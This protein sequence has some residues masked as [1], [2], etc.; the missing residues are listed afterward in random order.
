MNPEEKQKL[1][2]YLGEIL[3]V[4]DEGRDEA[5][6][7]P[8]WL[9]LLN[10]LPTILVEWLPFSV[11]LPLTPIFLKYIEANQPARLL[12]LFSEDG[13]VLI[14]SVVLCGEGLRETLT[15][16]RT[17]SR[18]IQFIRLALGV[19]AFLISVWACL[20]YK[21]LANPAHP[22]RLEGVALN[23]FIASLFVGGACQ[24]LKLIWRK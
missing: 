8:G 20:L 5:Q 16:S 19:A 3:K 23:T 14:I 12:K 10:E 24:T 13:E 11:V 21:D 18:L 2:T 7:R 15:A 6:D 22:A 9:T 17:D 4:L 1:R